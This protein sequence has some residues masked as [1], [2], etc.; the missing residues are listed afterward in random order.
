MQAWGKVHFWGDDYGFDEP[1]VHGAVLSLTPWGPAPLLDGTFR[2]LGTLPLS[3]QL[4]SQPCGLGVLGNCSKMS[5]CCLSMLG[6]VGGPPALPR[7]QE[8]PDKEARDKASPVYFQQY[9]FSAVLPLSG[10]PAPRQ[11]GGQTKS[12]S[13]MGRTSAKVLRLKHLPPPLSK[14][15]FE[16]GN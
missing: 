6:G 13:G 12:Q 11:E 2:A 10:F 7:L 8:K 5:G 3:H 14:D 4:P 1:I 9:I 15:A 16:S